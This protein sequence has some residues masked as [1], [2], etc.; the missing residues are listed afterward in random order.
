MDFHSER[1]LRLNN[2]LMMTQP[3]RDIRV[4]H[5]INQEPYLSHGIT[6]PLFHLI[7]FI[8][9]YVCE[10]GHTNN[11]DPTDQHHHQDQGVKPGCKYL[12]AGRTKWCE[13]DNQATGNDSQLWRR[14]AVGYLKPFQSYYSSKTWGR[15]SAATLTRRKMCQ[16][17]TTNDSFIWTF[18]YSTALF[19]KNRDVIVAW[20]FFFFFP[21]VLVNDFFL[22]ACLEDFIENARL[23]I[24]E[25]FCR[26]H[27]CISIRYSVLEIAH[28]SQ[29]CVCCLLFVREHIFFPNK[30]WKDPFSFW[31]CVMDVLQW[32]LLS[33]SKSRMLLTFRFFKNIQQ[34]KWQNVKTWDSTK[35][36]LLDWNAP[37]YSALSTQHAGRQA[38]HDA[39]GGGEVDRQPHS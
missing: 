15:S 9:H 27:Q 24:F 20:A 28:L 31:T 16:T 23:F 37:S 39:R 2:K 3:H 19:W 36:C 18:L 25:T 10:C 11:H 35:G 26:I 14:R 6:G 5:T 33:T 30:G 7:V 4:F 29:C 21:Q 13:T 12:S 32:L 8:S 34:K 38:Q 1:T 22:V 17:I